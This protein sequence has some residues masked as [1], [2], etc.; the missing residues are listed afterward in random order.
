VTG[1]PPSSLRAGL[2]RAARLGERSRDDRRVGDGV[3]PRYWADEVAGRHLT[4]AIATPATT[5]MTTGTMHPQQS[6]LYNLWGMRTPAESDLRRTPEELVGDEGEGAGEPYDGPAA[7]AARPMTADESARL[8][9]R[10]SPRPYRPPRHDHDQPVAPNR[11]TSP[12]P[13]WLPRDDQPSS[14]TEPAWP[15]GDPGIAASTC[16]PNRLATASRLGLVGRAGP[17]A[18]RNAM[19]PR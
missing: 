18:R 2:G 15:E 9:P 3:F 19:P 1:P 4:T 14:T 5:A 7:I 11:M 17:A 16:R 13:S 10:R 8:S 12:T 6:P